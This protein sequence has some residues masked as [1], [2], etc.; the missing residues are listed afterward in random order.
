[1]EINEEYLKKK[2]KEIMDKFGI[3]RVNALRNISYVISLNSS[4]LVTILLKIKKIDNDYFNDLFD[5]AIFGF[6]SSCF[7]DFDSIYN[8][9]EHLKKHISILEKKG[10]IE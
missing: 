1:M 9:L 5:S 2:E 6:Y 3:E 7:K 8:R 10:I 4:E